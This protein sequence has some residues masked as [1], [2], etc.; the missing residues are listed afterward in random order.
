MINISTNH[1]VSWPQ[2]TAPVVAPVSAVTAVRPVQD[3]RGESQAG[4]GGGQGGAAAQRREASRSAASET[5]ATPEAAP[6]LPREAAKS[7]AAMPATA[8]QNKELAAAKQAEQDELVKKAE[9]Q[10]TKLQLQ[11]ALTRVWQASAAVVERALASNSDTAS[12]LAVSSDTQAPRKLM[13]PEQP[14]QPPV[15]S[16][17]WPVMPEDGSAAQASA[18]DVDPRPVQEVVA[19]DEHGNSSLAP[20]EAGSLVSERV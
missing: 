1:V 14:E 16:L 12:R 9:E 2:A 13:P 3:G 18:I 10:S 8:A 17:P 6:L 20:L 15:E 19:Y 4:L 11:E 5:A 7:A